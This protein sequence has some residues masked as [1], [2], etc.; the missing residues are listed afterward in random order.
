MKHW[1]VEVEGSGG[2]H[3]GRREIISFLSLFCRHRAKLD[4][5]VQQEQSQLDL[6]VRRVANLTTVHR[7]RVVLEHGLEERGAV[8]ARVPLQ[9]VRPWVGSGVDD[10]CTE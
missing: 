4:V 6:L 1:V 5:L 3:R 2:G 7:L 9:E 8:L 10:E